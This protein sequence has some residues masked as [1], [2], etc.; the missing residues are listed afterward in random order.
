MRKEGRRGFT[1]IS[2][3][4]YSSASSRVIHKFI[5]SGGQFLP[6]VIVLLPSQL[7]FYTAKKKIVS[8]CFYP[9]SDLLYK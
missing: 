3:S 7:P 9:R 2:I 5:L 1:V 6:I 8:L 4:H